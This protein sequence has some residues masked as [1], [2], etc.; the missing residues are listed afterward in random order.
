MIHDDDVALHRLAPH[1]GDEAPAPLTALLANA[2]LS[3][4]VKLVPEQAGL[5][6]LRQLGAVTGSRSL[7]PRSDGPILFD[8]FQ[9]AQHRLIRQI[10]Q[11]LPAQVIIP[12]LHVANREP[13]ARSRKP[14][15]R[16]LQKWNVLIKKLLLQILRPRRD[17][18][19]LSRPNRRHQVRQRLA[20][21]GACFHNQMAL[22]FQRLFD[23]LCHL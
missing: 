13:G 18:D 23:S 3:A 19:A 5:G 17:N 16:L 9:P 11:F 8:L 20:R 21:A 12:T 2:G 15:Q 1:F 22:F 6:Q 4:C 7:L 10:V 14:I